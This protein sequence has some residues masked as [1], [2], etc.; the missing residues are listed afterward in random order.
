V[1]V[2]MEVWWRSVV[3]VRTV[4]GGDAVELRVLVSRGG[5]GEELR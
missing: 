4:Q 1:A 2:A 5:G 3:T